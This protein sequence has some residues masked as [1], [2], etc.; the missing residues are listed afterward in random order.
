MYVVGICSK[1]C[2]DTIAHVIK[3][4]DEGLDTYFAQEQNLIILSD[5]SEDRTHEVARNTET[6]VEKIILTQ[7]GGPGKGNGVKTILKEVQKR[8]ASGVALVDGDLTSVQP[9]WISKLLTP[10]QEGYDEVIPFY[11]RHPYDGV[12]TNQIAY[13]LTTV[14][15]G[16]EIRQPIGGEFSLSGE[17]TGKILKNPLFPQEFGIDIFLST[18]GIVEDLKIVETVLGFKEHTSTKEYK[19]PMKLLIPMYYQVLNSLFDLYLGYKDKAKKVTTISKV[20]RIGEIPQGETKSPSVDKDR[21]FRQIR[22]DYRERIGD[23]S[24]IDFLSS[25]K[26]EIKPHLEKEEITLPL[27]VWAKCVFL[28]LNNYGY[29]K[30]R[31]LDVLRVF[32]EARYMGLVRET[33]NMPQEEAESRIQDQVRVFW[34][35]RNMLKF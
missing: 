15:Y 22:Q 23:I 9:D 12:I 1:N 31:T 26:D 18:T 11:I 3:T 6:K 7:E 5:L 8:R 4:V 25:I 24:R 27:E 14:L 10:I 13:P 21:W 16:K 33:E 29:D 19:D 2:E 28:S 32:W 20:E 17:A 35:Y 34:K 30:Q